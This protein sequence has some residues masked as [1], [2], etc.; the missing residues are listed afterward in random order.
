MRLAAFLGALALFAAVQPKAQAQ[1]IIFEEEVVTRKLTIMPGGM[2]V[3]HGSVIIGGPRREMMKGRVKIGSSII[4]HDMLP[5]TLLAMNVAE[6]TLTVKDGYYGNRT[7]NLNKIAVTSGCVGPFCVGDQVITNDQLTGTV[8]GF[9]NDGDLVVKDGYYGNRRK[10]QNSLALT[11]GCSGMFCIG[12]KVIT[13]DNMS[14]VVKG[15]HADGSIVVKDGYYGM[16]THSETSLSVTEGVCANI[17][18]QRVRF[19]RR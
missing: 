6:N 14:G 7:T 2:E 4:T 12:D 9:F 8:M 16:R 5:G 3:L 18:I 10:S 19:C 13:K 15:F 11:Y 17:F 1:A